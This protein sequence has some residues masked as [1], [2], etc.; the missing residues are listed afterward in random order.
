MYSNLLNYFID[1]VKNEARESIYIE[2]RKN[3]QITDKVFVPNDGNGGQ[4]IEQFFFSKGEFAESEAFVLPLTTDL[5]NFLKTRSLKFTSEHLYLTL[6]FLKTDSYRQSSN[7]VDLIPVYF[8]ELSYEITGNQVSFAIVD[9]EPYFN[10]GLFDSLP[11]DERLTEEEKFA[12]REDILNVEQWDSKVAV[13]EGNF[14]KT[15]LENLTF[16]P[17]LFIGD[18]PKFYEYVTKEI[19]SI[20]K[21]YSQDIDK[22]ALKY[23]LAQKDNIADLQ[24]I[25]SNAGEN[26]LEIYELNREQEQAVQQA[27][28]TPFTVITGPP[29][30]GKSQVVLNLLANL[31]YANKTALLASKNNKAVNTILEKLSKIE[32]HYYP[33]VRLGNRRE[34]SQ[35]KERLLAN[36]NKP[37]PNN[38]SEELTGT[39]GIHDKI[40]KCYEN[41]DAAMAKFHEYYQ[42]VNA[43]EDV[44]QELIGYKEIHPRQKPVLEFLEG[45]KKEGTA[46]FTG[47]ISVID[48]LEASAEE[49]LALFKDTRAKRE[50]LTSNFRQVVD[51]NLHEIALPNSQVQLDLHELRRD[52][53]TALNKDLSWITRFLQRW[54]GGLSPKR[55]FKR[56]RRILAGQ[57]ESIQKVLLDD[58]SDVNPQNLLLSVQKLLAMN[59]YAA[60]RKELLEKKD[61]F[62]KGTLENTLNQFDQS[63][64]GSKNR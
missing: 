40:A 54:F 5:Q 12:I 7:F 45:G 19:E 34:K 32:D 16:S 41:F 29:G 3:G 50:K 63:F 21:Y 48:H 37:C 15:F 18:I 36:L 47:L 49:L 33:F 10:F 46:N 64:P 60:A 58:L 20:R 11:Y 23:F 44:H 28:N 53:E 31:S 22:T 61:K 62:F 25:P 6:K 13:F 14:P 8:V 39:A 57:S 35:G 4:Q 56:F 55:L 26:Y 43:L 30:T 1:C 38:L 42:R 24:A 2:G 59:A 27:L 9:Y 51:N 17:V 52:L